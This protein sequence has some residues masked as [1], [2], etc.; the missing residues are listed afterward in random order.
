MRI[1]L[2][3]MVFWFT[4]FFSSSFFGGTGES[5]LSLFFFGIVAEAG[6]SIF[7]LLL[8]VLTFGSKFPEF[9]FFPLLG[10]GFGSLTFIVFL[11]FYK[12]T[13]FRLNV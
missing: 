5:D 4:I 2:I 8:L 3:F 7:L 11:F 6:A 9:S 13:I 1:L 10:H 12:K